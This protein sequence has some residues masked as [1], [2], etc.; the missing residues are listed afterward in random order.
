MNFD[1]EGPFVLKRYGKKKVLAKSTLADLEEQLEVRDERLRTACGCYLFALRAAKGFIP[2]Y[3][4]QACKRPLSREALNG[5]NLTKYNEVMSDHK[6]TP[7]LFL[8]PMMTPEWRYRKLSRKLGGLAALD[9]LER[10]LIA[11][12]IQKNPYLINNK[13]TRFL[14]NI[15]VRGFFN[16]GH[17][18][19]TLRSQKLTSALW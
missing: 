6:G 3:V 7:V 19:S 9:F 5:T 8:L 15:Y 12:A 4:G 17:G 18:D 1:V 16:A 10:W 11:T 13:E 2:W 14:R